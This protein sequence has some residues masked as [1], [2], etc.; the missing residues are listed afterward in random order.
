MM[1]LC[2]LIY[3]FISCWDG[4]KLL[5]FSWNSRFRKTSI[6]KC[7]LRIT[8]EINSSVPSSSSVAYSSYSL[9]IA[10]FKM[11]AHSSWSSALLLHFFTPNVYRSSSTQS[12][13][14]SLG[15]PGFLLPPGFISSLT[16]Y[17]Q[18]WNNGYVHQ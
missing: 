9:T 17:M 1:K 14:L 2:I 15:L 10:P 7:F 13:H 3:L 8:L 18:R 4:N 12:S 6:T 11:I 5:S 16:S